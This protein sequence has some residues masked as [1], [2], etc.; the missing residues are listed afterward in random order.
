MVSP[1]VLLIR[2]CGL[3]SIYIQV[4]HAGQLLL[5]KVI[6][7]R[8]IRL[9]VGVQITEI[10]TFTNIP[11]LHTGSLILMPIGRCYRICRSEHFIGLTV[12]C[13][14][15][16]AS[17]ARVQGLGARTGS[18]GRSLDLLAVLDTSIFIGSC[19]PSHL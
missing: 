15:H 12:V 8:L 18:S 5:S 11:L 17:E 2:F 4:S 1:S 3:T 9:I 13:R 14:D 10:D 7:Q 16:V 6:S 19:K